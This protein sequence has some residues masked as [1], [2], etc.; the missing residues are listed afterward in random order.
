MPRHAAVSVLALPAVAVL[1][2]CGADSEPVEP[3]DLAIVGGQLPDPLADIRNTLQIDRVML[4]GV[5]VDRDA[6][7]PS[8]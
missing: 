6:L 2:A 3:T 1:A 7:L 4:R 8:E 5:W